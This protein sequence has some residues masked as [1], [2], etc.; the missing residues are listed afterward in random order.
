MI[1]S[2]SDM[3]GSLSDKPEYLDDYEKN[4]K[5]FKQEFQDLENLKPDHAGWSGS[6]Y[7]FK[8]YK[9]ADGYRVAMPAR[10]HPFRIPD[11]MYFEDYLLSKTLFPNPYQALTSASR[12][13]QQRMGN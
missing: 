7:F 12:I 13:M 8:V 4:D 2:P 10:Y 9:G 3:P 1:L 6:L 5:S 11:R